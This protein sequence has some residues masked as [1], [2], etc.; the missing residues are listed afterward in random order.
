LDPSAEAEG[1]TVAGH[2]QAQ[3]LGDAGDALRQVAVGRERGHDPVVR[4]ARVGLVAGGLGALQ[5]LHLQGEELAEQ[6]RGAAAL[7]A[8]HQRGGVV[9]GEQAPELLAPHH[10]DGHG[11]RDAHVA[12]ILDVHR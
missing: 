10:R 5:A 9:A 12:E 3:L 1:D 4:G 7:V 11:G 6:L 8:R 2:Q